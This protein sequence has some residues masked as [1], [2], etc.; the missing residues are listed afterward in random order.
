MGSERDLG[1][2]QMHVDGL[3]RYEQLVYRGL[4]ARVI[5]FAID[6]AMFFIHIEM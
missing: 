4:S 6:R 5:L 3:A 1:N 2:G